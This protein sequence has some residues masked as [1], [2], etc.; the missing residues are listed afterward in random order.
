M[1]G[2][3]GARSQGLTLVKRLSTDLTRVIHPHQSRSMLALPRTQL[4]LFMPDS[5]RGPRRVIREKCRAAGELAQA[6]IHPTE[7]SVY[8]GQGPSG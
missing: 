4:G 6:L 2:V 1:A 7:K 3:A 5:R 8:P